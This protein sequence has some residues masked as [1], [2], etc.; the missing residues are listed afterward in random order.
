MNNE[1]LKKMLDD[2]DVEICVK[3]KSQDGVVEPFPIG[4]SIFIR[5]VTNYYT[6]RVVGLVD[7]FV[8]LADAAWIA[9]TGRFSTAIE[10]GE[11]NEVEP[12]TTCY[13]SRAS[14]VDVVPWLHPLP[15][16]QQ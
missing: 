14:I 6:G 16:K 9:D 5:T 11:F 7:G 12:L 4:G 8:Q 1:Q 3:R 13:V 10:T 2:P 15:R